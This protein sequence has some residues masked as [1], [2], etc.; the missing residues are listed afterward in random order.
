[1]DRCQAS[2]RVVAREAGLAETPR[3]R[4]VTDIAEE[5]NLAM[6]Q[7]RDTYRDLAFSAAWEG[8]RQETVDKPKD[9]PEQ[10]PAPIGRPC[11]S[12]A[13]GEALGHRT[14]WACSGWSQSA[15]IGNP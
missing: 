10:A 15:G 5:T 9:A 14:L 7:L 6:T 12:L 8:E 2:R 11:P 4:T 13:P 1:M 3:S